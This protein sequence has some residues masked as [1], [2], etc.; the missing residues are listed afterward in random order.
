MKYLLPLLMLVAAPAFA[1]DDEVLVEQLMQRH[2]STAKTPPARQAR[3][4]PALA[5]VGQP[6]R[7]RTV[8][9]GLYLGVLA[10]ADA[11]AIHLD[12]AT[13]GQVLGYALPRSAVAQIE[14]VAAP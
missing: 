2:A 14:A 6:V 8:D 5:L 13:S 7:V 4:D 10:A 12:I 3:T 11:A 9:R 1:D